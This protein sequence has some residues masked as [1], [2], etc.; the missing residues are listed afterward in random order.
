MTKALTVADLTMVSEQPLV[1]DLALAERLGFERPSDIRKLIRRNLT[2]L[3]QHGLICATVAQIKP[4]PQNPRGAGKPS[5]AFYL[6][7]G[8]ALVVCMLSRTERAVEV[9]TQ[10]I[11]VYMAWRRGQLA[12]VSG[13][14]PETHD[15][16]EPIARRQALLEQASRHN[17]AIVPHSFAAAVPHLMPPRK[18][19]RFPD[20]HGDFPVRE[21]VIA[22][23]RQTT[24]KI[25]R[26]TLV[27]EF[28]PERAPSISAIQRYWAVLD[29]IKEG[30][31]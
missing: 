1:M 11:A 24:L 30:N 12:E 4:S 9:R 15:R 25:T 7:E 2:E 3:E 22:L 29:G 8:Q 18:C 28:G 19:R 6:N 14:A 23:H 17:S 31:P 13:A 5:E 21:R 10:V 27:R 16:V 20:F 26:E